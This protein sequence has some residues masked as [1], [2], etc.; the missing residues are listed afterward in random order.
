MTPEEKAIITEWLDMATTALSEAED[1]TMEEMEAKRQEWIQ[2]YLKMM[3]PA[4][5]A[6]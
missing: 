4:S 5:E 1:L 3:A 6:S 2:V